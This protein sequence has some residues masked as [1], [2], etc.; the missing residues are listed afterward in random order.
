M[1]EADSPSGGAAEQ[2][3]SWRWLA[4]AL[5]VLVT[6]GVVGGLVFFRLTSRTPGPQSVGSVT[7]SGIDFK[8][9]LPVLAGAAGGFISFPDGGITIDRSVAVGVKSY[10]GGFGFTYD[11]RVARWV[12]VPSSA[13]SPDGRSYGYLAQTTGVPGQ[14]TSMSLHTHEIVS[15]KDRVLWEGA[16]SPMSGSVTWLATG[17]YF[18]AALSPAEPTSFG[19]LLPAVYTVDPNHPGPPRRVGPNPPPQTPSPDQ[20]YYSGPDSFGLFGGGAAWGVGNRVMK[21]APTTD[22]PP[23]P[24]TYGP[25]RVLR[26]DLRDG[27]V[28]T[29]Y[30]VA[31]TDIVSVMGLD[32]QGE[33]ILSL[34]TPKAPV[35]NTKTY[36]PPAVRLLLLTGPGQTVDIT[37]GNAG[38]HM[39]GGPTADSHGI[40]FGDWNAVW[41]Y[42]RTGGLRQVATIPAGVFPSPSPPPGF[43]A[44]PVAVPSGKPGM[45]AY[46]QGTLVN[47][48]GPCV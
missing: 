42:T 5:A 36:E 6:L 25:D 4:T 17:L 23:A 18:T 27:S 31:G 28:S 24:G 48:A 38:F 11:A 15:G 30:T 40:W 44:Q 14:N 32:A 45:P 9:R 12:P 34:F 13:L 2:Q 39:G 20:P 16:G 19:Q 37:A 10:K 47:P 26:M 3:R 8:C 33:P 41:I 1:N 7:V 46:M 21:K 29:W 22:G 35:P 43:P